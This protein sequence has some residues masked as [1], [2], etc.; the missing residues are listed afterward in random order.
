MNDMILMLQK[1]FDQA[2]IKMQ[3]TETEVVAIGG[4]ALILLALVATLALTGAFRKKPEAVIEE[5]QDVEEVV[6]EDTSTEEI[7]PEITDVPKEVKLEL[8]EP[9]EE[10]PEVPEVPTLE[11]EV[12]VETPEL[13]IVEEAEVIETP[14]VPLV[15]K[16]SWASRLKKG[17]SRSNSEV[18]GKLGKLFTSKDLTDEVLEEVEE[19]LYGADLGPTVAMELIDALEEVASKGNITEES[20]KTFLYDF[21]KERMDDVQKDVD[22]DLYNFDPA[23]KGKTKVIMVVGVNGAGKTTTIGK[24]ATKLTNQGAKVV[25]GACDTFRAAAVDQLQVW[26]ERAGAEMVRAK[27][28]AA[29]SGVGYEALEKAIKSS[30]DYCI[31]DTAGRLHT[32]GNLMEE[33]TK[34]KHKL[35][36]QLLTTI[37]KNFKSV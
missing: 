15:A 17:L 16:E 23:K 12:V 34:S 10:T 14:E 11:E 31:L 5:E 2:G 7:T 3:A 20:F 1:F 30:A 6:S 32:A 36:L 9:L 27:E 13:P 37:K 4:G 8:V 24:L 22:Q 25:V 28:G 33:L 18:W 21:L 29:P 26:C 19:L 35:R